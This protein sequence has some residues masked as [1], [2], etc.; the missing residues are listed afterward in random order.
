MSESVFKDMPQ[1]DRLNDYLQTA[2]PGEWDESVV[3]GLINGEVDLLAG[4][5]LQKGME[6]GLDERE[7]DALAFTGTTHMVSDWSFRIG[8][9][10]RGTCRATMN[11]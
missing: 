2:T 6:I 10:G 11:A 7:S 8:V 5:F 3:E 4:Y 9:E 1:P